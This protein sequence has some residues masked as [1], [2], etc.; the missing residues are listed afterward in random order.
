M[1]GEKYTVACNLS[2]ACAARVHTRQLAGGKSSNVR[3][4]LVVWAKVDGIA[5]EEKIV[6][7]D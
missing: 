6:T 7:G 3:A 5:A 2:R 4:Q 1:Q